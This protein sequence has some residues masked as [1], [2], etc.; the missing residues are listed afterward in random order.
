MSKWITVSIFT[1]INNVS[2]NIAKL[3]LGRLPRVSVDIL[4]GV[5]ILN[6][7]TRASPHLLANAKLHPN[8]SL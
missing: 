6:H 5:K 3:A 7:K 2:M 1:V 4:P 8:Q